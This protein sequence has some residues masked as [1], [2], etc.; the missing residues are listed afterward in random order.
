MLKLYYAPNTC[1]LA[2]RIALEEVGADYEAVRV[3]FTTEEQR[4]PPY[5]GINPHGRVP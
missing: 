4:K 2:S 1:A 5:L 3:D